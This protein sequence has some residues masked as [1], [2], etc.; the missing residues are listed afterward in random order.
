MKYQVLLVDDETIY[1]QYL[2]SMIP[3]KKWQC[4]ICG[5]AQNGEEAIH[6]AEEKNPDIIFMDINMSKLDGLDACQALRT[7]ENRA[8]IIIMTAYNEFSFAHRAIKLNV[9][10]YLLKPFDEGELEETLKKCIC[11]I[12]KERMQEQEQRENLLNHLLE[13]D[14]LDANR[15]Q[16]EG[17]LDNQWYVAVLFQNGPKVSGKQKIYDLLKQQFLGLGVD[18]YFLGNQKGY[19]I[20]IHMMQHKKISQQKIKGK[21]L[22]IQRNHPETEFLWVAVGDVV[23]GAKMLSETYRHAR[24]V[25]ENRVK[26]TGTVHSYEEVQ[27]LR[28][29][30]TFLSSN[31][32]NLLIRAFEKKDYEQVDQIIEK[33]FNLSSGQMFSFQY[34]ITTY[35]SLVTEI[36]NYYHYSEENNLTN[37]LNTQTSLISEISLCATKEQMLELVRNYVYEVFSDCLNVRLGNKKEILTGKIEDYLQKHYSDKSLSVNQIAENLYFENSYIRRVFK[38]QTGKTIVQRLEEIRMEKARELLAKGNYRN[39]E[40]AELTGYCDQYYFS[41]RFKLLC[42]CTPSEYQAGKFR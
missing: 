18:S 31:D 27:K 11:E 29:E 1:L 23:K 2:Q 12:D 10:D 24:L 35:Y 8:K 14:T 13:T 39:S 41:K 36:Y 7:K 15:M 34:V 42:G 38:L 4:E 33:M 40:I 22:E 20:V 9:F 17:L 26:M 32:T 25:R 30:V 3:W 5:C 6:M 37:I 28:A 16:T 19:E 21:Y